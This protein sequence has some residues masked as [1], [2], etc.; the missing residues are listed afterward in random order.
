MD[1]KFNNKN[2]DEI[3]VFLPK[4]ELDVETMKQIKNL[5]DN[6]T[7]NHPRFM[8]DTHKGKGCCVGLTSIIKDGLIPNYV[9][10]D[11]GC[12]ISC[13]PLNITIDEKKYPKIDKLIKERVPMGTGIVNNEDISR[14]ED[15][16]ELFDKCNLQFKKFTKFITRI[17]RYLSKCLF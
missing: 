6:P 11:I 7:L 10:G 13:Y 9:G 16:D 3:K 4:L 14:D 8:P 17:Q 2:G 5:A 15:W 1:Y 12:G